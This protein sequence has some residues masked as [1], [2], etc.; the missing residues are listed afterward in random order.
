MD[1]RKYKYMVNE[2]VYRPN[3]IL[4][5]IGQNYWRQS[6]STILVPINVHV[7]LLVYNYLLIL[8]MYFFYLSKNSRCSCFLTSRS[9]SYFI[10]EWLRSHCFFPI[11]LMLGHSEENNSI[12][13]YTVQTHDSLSSLLRSS[14]DSFL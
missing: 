2:W 1:E 14:P 3:C 4:S 6:F 5:K 7:L 9:N 10:S 11:F 8:P 13:S 12:E